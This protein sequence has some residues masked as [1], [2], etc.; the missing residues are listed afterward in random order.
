MK[1]RADAVDYEVFSSEEGSS[2]G[3]Y[4]IPSSFATQAQENSQIILNIYLDLIQEFWEIRIREECVYWK[5]QSQKQ[6]L[7]WNE[8]SQSTCLEDAKAVSFEEVH[9]L[10]FKEQ[11]FD[12]DK[13]V[14]SM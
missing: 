10:D 12:R 9:T 6:G 5:E 13:T 3:A 4:V 14:I 8:E 2:N 11:Q 7:H 1:K